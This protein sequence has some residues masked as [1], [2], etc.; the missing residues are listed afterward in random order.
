MG[1]QSCKKHHCY[2]WCQALS[3][4]FSLV[5]VFLE[6]K[7]MMCYCLALLI[8]WSLLVDTMSNLVSSPGPFPAFEYHNFEMLGKCLRARLHLTHFVCYYFP[9]LFTERH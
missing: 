8:N 2:I 7:S 6:Y 1:F 9:Y 5:S 3:L 4:S